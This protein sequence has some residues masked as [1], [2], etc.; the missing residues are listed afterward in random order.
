VEETFAQAPQ[1]TYLTKANF[2]VDE[3]DRVEK[4]VAEA[5]HVAHIT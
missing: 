1:V 2:L 5:P 3:D 4:T